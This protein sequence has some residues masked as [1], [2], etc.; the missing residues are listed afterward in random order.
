MGILSKNQPPNN[1]PSTDT[2]SQQELNYLLIMLS[3][4][5]FE[6]KDVLLLSGIVQKLNNQLESK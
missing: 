6:G 5:K 2:L 4:A 1:K 3:E